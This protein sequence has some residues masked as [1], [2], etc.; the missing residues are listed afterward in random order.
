[1][2]LCDALIWLKSIN[3]KKY[4]AKKDDFI[5]DTKRNDRLEIPTIQNSASYEAL[6][7]T[8]FHSKFNSACNGSV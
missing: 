6:L 1:M 5:A 2:G 3:G 4:N 7:N 8:A